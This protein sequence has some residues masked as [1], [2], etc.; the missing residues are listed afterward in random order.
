MPRHLVLAL[1]LP[2]LLAAS[3]SAQVPPPTFPAETELVIV[4]VVVADRKGGG[5]VAGL[6]AADFEI[7]EDGAPQ[8]I[9]S[10]E[11]F[12]APPPPAPAPVGPP[13]APGSPAPP[14]AAPAAV[15][16]P[17]AVSTNTAPDVRAGRSFVVV[18]DDVNVTPPRASAAKAAVAE[19]LRK[20]VR[21][22]DR[23]MLVTT[24]G[25]AW[26]SARIP[27]GRDELLAI[28]ERLEAL[29]S[30]DPG[31][32]RMSDSEALRIHLYRDVQVWDRVTRRY[33][34]YGV[35]AAAMR[36]DPADPPPR[37]GQR[38]RRGA[39]PRGLHAG[40][41][42]PRRHAERPRARPRRDGPG[43]G[44]EVPPPRVRGLHLRAEPRRLPAG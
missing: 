12:V 24:S 11:A 8:S 9:S 34:A 42:P 28:V 29:F 27:A 36:G 22:G 44:E 10:F 43:Q 16:L 2:A 31:P 40:D 26:W 25:S 3:A 33:E 35:S 23:V 19:F 18:F 4:D 5:G 41:R 32:E 39:G 7:T 21:D 30:P 20:G 1:G 13:T 37:N 6:T 38:L 15:V 14:V 17:T